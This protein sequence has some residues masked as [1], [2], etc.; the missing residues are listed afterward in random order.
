ME[1]DQWCG[2]SLA[3]V[4]WKFSSCKVKVPYCGTLSIAVEYFILSIAK[5]VIE[6]LFTFQSLC[7]TIFPADVADE[8]CLYARVIS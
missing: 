5:L 3:V 1:V 7:E 8:R 4:S 2:G 6:L